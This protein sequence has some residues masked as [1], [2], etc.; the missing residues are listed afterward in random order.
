MSYSNGPKMVTNGLVM[1]LDAG[2]TK[3]YV[4]GSL[5]WNNMIG[6][7]F[8]TASLV[9]V[10]YTGSNNGAL[11]FNGVNNS[12][13]YFQNS[14]GSSYFEFG[15]ITGSTNDFSVEFWAYNNN[16]STNQAYYSSR[17][18]GSFS[19]SMY[20]GTYPTGGLEW[21]YYNPANTFSAS[22]RL[23]ENSIPVA[24]WFHCVCTRQH[25][26][27]SIYI[28][29]RLS[30]TSSLLNVTAS[31]PPTLVSLGSQYTSTSSSFNVLNGRMSLFK[32]YRKALTPNE[33]LVSYSSTKG[34]YLAPISNITADFWQTFEVETLTAANLALTDNTTSG[35][36]SILNTASFAITSSAQCRNSTTIN[37]LYDNGVKGITYLANVT[38]VDGNSNLIYNFGTN[39]SR[40]S[41]RFYINS[42]SIPLFGGKSVIQIVNSL[43]FGVAPNFAYYYNPSENPLPRLYNVGMP[44]MFTWYRVEMYCDTSTTCKF[45]MYTINGTFLG[46]NTFTLTG[47]PAAIWFFRNSGATSVTSLMDN[48]VIDWTNATYPIGP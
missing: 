14:S 18:S 28:N 25:A 6:A 42:T 34:R 10:S 27:H 33:V 16:F 5:I 23:P 1:C 48:L 15:N 36:W 44:S 29:S 45:S 22:L 4:S 43:G 39:R 24:T 32:L 2:S 17:L 12:G 41:M 19:G 26:T 21:Y 40:F 11:L 20:I 47:A 38:V 37:N 3:S 8:P 9:A 35:T 7:Q 13:A 31:A 30:T 46:E